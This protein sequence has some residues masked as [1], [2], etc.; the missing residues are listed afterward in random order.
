MIT[1][2][3]AGKL[4]TFEGIDASGKSEQFM[5][6]KN[7]LQA[8]HQAQFKKAFFT[9]EPDV[10]H[11]SGR[12]IYDL[13]LGRHSTLNIDDLHPFEMQSRYFRNRI[14]HYREKVI[15]NLAKEF[16][17][18]SDR[19]VGSVCFGVSSPADF[20]PLMGI[21]GQ[22]FLGAEV[23]FIWPDAILIYDVPADVA[24]ARNVASVKKLD[25]FERNMEFQMRIRENYLAFTKQYSNC[26]VIDGS[27]QPEEVFIKTKEILI[28]IL[29]L[30]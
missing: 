13:L 14:W 8:Y 12:E 6:W 25:Y 18:I 5:R 16:H 28:P 2:P 7:Y 19:G 1:N 29:G 15:L 23:P 17:V 9:K 26:Y 3:Y 20:K 4:I 11:E 21:Q 30:V 27:G 24:R 22:A 10:D